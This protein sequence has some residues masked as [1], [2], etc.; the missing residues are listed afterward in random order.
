M[1]PMGPHYRANVPASQKLDDELT[2][3]DP[4]GT[5]RTLDRRQRLGLGAA[6]GTILVRGLEQ[7]AVDAG[8]PPHEIGSWAGDL[9]VAHHAER[10][11][12]RDPSRRVSDP[13]GH[14]SIQ[15]R[16]F[17]ASATI[18]AVPATTGMRRAA[19]AGR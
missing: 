11:A 15:A 9:A 12:T 1:G 8:L 6:G 5:P 2:G 3:T 10:P 7:V 4:A 19:H 17:S 13:L 14:R 16:R 18:A